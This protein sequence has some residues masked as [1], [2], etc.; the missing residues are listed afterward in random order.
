MRYVSIKYSFYFYLVSIHL[1]YFTNMVYASS[2]DLQW[3]SQE[4]FKITGYYSPEKWQNFY[5]QGSNEDERI[6]NWDGTHGASWRAVFNGMIAAPNIYDFGTKIYL[7]WFGVGSVEDRWWAIVEKGER[8]EKYHRIDIWMW[9]WELWLQRA[10]SFGVIYKKW[11]VCP[12]SSWLKVAFD[13]EKFS[14]LSNFFQSTLWRVQLSK[15]RNDPR[16]GVLQAYLKKLWYFTNEVNNNFWESTK[17]ALCNFQNTILSIKKTDFWCGYFGSTTRNALKKHLEKKWLLWHLEMKEPVDKK[18]T[19]ENKNVATSEKQKSTTIEKSLWSKQPL[20]DKKKS[21]DSSI[22]SDKKNENLLKEINPINEWYLQAW[23]S[24]NYKFLWEIPFW[25]KSMEVKL[26]QRK[27][28]W[29]GYYKKNISGIYD[30]YTKSSIFAFQV[31][32]KILSSDDTSVSKWWLW[33]KTRELLNKV[34]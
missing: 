32:K 33:P 14:I 22:I 21:L 27:L 20:Q 31:D 15:W 24:K 23:D 4:Y 3:C 5:A 12:K 6:L 8:G 10:L 11:R 9:K 34:K 30:E 13:M 17:T 25:K 1:I 2:L 19:I 26:L 16:V 18:N 7:P 28:Q 29:M